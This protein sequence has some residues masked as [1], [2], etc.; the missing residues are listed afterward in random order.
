MAKKALP[1][2]QTADA[3][4]ITPS[5]TLLLVDDPNNTTNQYSFCYVLNN[6]AGATVKVQTIEG[7]TVTVYVAQGET[8][9]GKVP[10]MIKQIF[11]TS[12][13]PPASL[14]ALIPFGGSF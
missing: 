2:L 13:T 5:D 10:L 11:A 3:F 6:S 8:V 12:P 1:S 4:A 9:G 14:T 7:S